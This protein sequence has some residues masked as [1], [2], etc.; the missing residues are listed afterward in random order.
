MTDINI[1][2]QEDFVT[3]QMWGTE[4]GREIQRDIEVPNSVAYI[5][6]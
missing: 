5:D 6:Y 2:C 1:K 3:D 4:C